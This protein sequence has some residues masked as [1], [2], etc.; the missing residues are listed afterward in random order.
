MRCP[1]EYST[2]IRS[3]KVNGAIGEGKQL[4]HKE[5]WEVSEFFLTVLGQI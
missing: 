3:K 4:D 1:N 5:N 2:A